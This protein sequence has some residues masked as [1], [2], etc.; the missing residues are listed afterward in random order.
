MARGSMFEF[1]GGDPAFRA[2]ATALHQRCLADPVLNHP[3]SRP[4]D[5]QHLEHLAAYWAEV[6]GGPDR[7][8]RAHGG[9]SAM[10]AIHAGQGAGEDFGSRFAA[11]FMQAVD[12]AHFPNERALRDGLRSYIEWAVRE[13]VSYAPAQARVPTGLPVPRWGWSGLE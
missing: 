4:G 12:D 13:V 8:S 6:F 5:P 10:L 11:C 9:H 1:A 7:Y 2:L 3:F